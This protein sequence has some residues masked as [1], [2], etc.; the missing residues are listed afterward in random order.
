V[1]W[2]YTECAAVVPGLLVLGIVLAAGDHDLTRDRLRAALRKTVVRGGDRRGGAGLREDCDVLRL[3]MRGAP[4][5]ARLPWEF[6][7]DP[8]LVRTREWR[9]EL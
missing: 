5:L 1:D 6:L 2:D 7:F 3:V 4:E 8:N 9:Y